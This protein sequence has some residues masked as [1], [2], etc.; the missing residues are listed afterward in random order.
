MEFC[1]LQRCGGRKHSMT[2]DS[3]D[4]PTSTSARTFPDDF[5]P[6]APRLDPGTVTTSEIVEM[7]WDDET[8]FDAIEAQTGL[9]EAEVI[10]LMRREMKP[11]SFRMWR[12]RV[13]GRGSKHAKADRR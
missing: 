2:Q 1:S 10:A 8:S 11:S 6:D 3:A 5:V 12:Q 4:T 7:A 9:A 13:N